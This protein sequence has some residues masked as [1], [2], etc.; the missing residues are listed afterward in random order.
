MLLA[1]AA[2]TKTPKTWHHEIRYCVPERG[3][4]AAK[5]PMRLA[6]VTST[7]STRSVSGFES[8]MH[9]STVAY[10]DLSTTLYV[11]TFDEA[12]RPKI[13][14]AVRVPQSLTNQHQITW[15][16]DELW[17]VMDGMTCNEAEPRPTVSPC[18][19]YRV[20]AD[21]VTRVTAFSERQ[22]AMKRLRPYRSTV[23]NSRAREG[24]GGGAGVSCSTREVSVEGA[25]VAR[26]NDD[27]E[28]VGK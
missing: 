26:V 11:L 23:A 8:F 20:T 9:M 21:N 10:A 1:L 4:A 16:K 27:G 5:Q 17:L 13:R 12:A 6:V 2:C 7:Q 28:L 15:L 22:E 19:M 14:K 18:Q 25:T 3:A 24:G